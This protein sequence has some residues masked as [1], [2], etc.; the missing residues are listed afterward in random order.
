[1]KQY[2]FL[3]F[4]F[5]IFS[6]SLS[7][8][9]FFS[10]D[11]DNEKE[12]KDKVC[13]EV[14]SRGEGVFRRLLHNYKNI[15]AEE[16]K[17]TCLRNVY[18]NI[19]DVCI[20][21]VVL[22]TTWL[23]YIKNE[24]IK[25]FLGNNIASAV[26]KAKDDRVVI[27]DMCLYGTKQFIKNNK[28]EPIKIDSK[29]FQLFRRLKKVVDA[30]VARRFVYLA[31]YFAVSDKKNTKKLLN[32]LI[33]ESLGQ[34]KLTSWMNYLPGNSLVKGGIYTFIL[35]FV[36]RNIKKLEDDLHNNFII[37]IDLRNL[38]DNAFKFKKYMMKDKNFY[39]LRVKTV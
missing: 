7:G 31:M 18:Y 28:A 23:D 37:D 16:E 39:D 22:K 6:H 11:K 34:S 32:K 20:H 2:I 1:M 24:K 25:N 33:D 21:E 26:K 3:I 30:E 12:N 35:W 14:I 8:M 17:N 36:E 15:K 4:V 38:K 19:F 29:D 5:L 13:K 10:K 27:V 9:W